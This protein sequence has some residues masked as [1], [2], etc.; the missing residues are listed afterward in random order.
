MFVTVIALKYALLVSQWSYGH[1]LKLTDSILFEQHDKSSPF[2]STHY[3]VLYPQ[4]GDRIVTIDS[5]TSFHPMH[6]AP[7][8]RVSVEPPSSALNMT[9]PAFAVERRRLQHSA[10]SYRSISPARRVL[11]SKPASCRCCSRSLGQTDRRMDMS[12]RYR[13]SASHTRCQQV[14]AVNFVA[15]CN[16]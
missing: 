8:Q 1:F 9:L 11:G 10:R 2:N 4:N 5:V 7:P 14:S 3:V 13:D 12:D 15:S 6:N 16:T